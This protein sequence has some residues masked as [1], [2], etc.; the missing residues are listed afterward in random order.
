MKWARAFAATSIVVSIISV[1]RPFTV[2][3]FPAGHD[4]PAHLTYAHLFDR[5]IRQGQFPVRWTEWARGGQGQPLFNFYQPGLY[6]IV[7][8]VRAATGLSLSRALKVSVVLLWWIGGLLLFL[9]LSQFGRWPAALGAVL[10]V[11]SPYLM[12]DVNVRAAYPELAALCFAPGVLLSIDRLS[13]SGRMEYT[14]SGACFVALVLVCHLPAFLIFS[15]L[16][17]MYALY[18][19]RTLE[20]AGVR[21]SRIPARIFS[22]VLLAGLGLGMATFY[23]LPALSERQFVGLSV[24]TSGYFDYAHHFVAP[25]QWVRFDWGFGSSIDGP[26]D[27]LS[28]QIGILQWI[29]IAAAVVTTAERLIKG[30]LNRAAGWICF[31][32]GFIAFGMLMMSRA[33]HPVWAAFP[34]LIYLQFP[35]RYLMLIS[36]CCAACAAALLSRV[37]SEPAQI[38][39][40]L[41][42]LA[43]QLSAARP[44]HKPKAYFTADEMNIYDTPWTKATDISH[45]YFEVPYL[46]RS[47]SHLPAADIGRWTLIKGRADVREVSLK[48][49]EVI[50]DVNAIDGPDA[51]HVSVNSY[52]FPGWRARL[53]GTDVA[54][55]QST[56]TDYMTVRIPPGRHRLEVKFTNTPIRF[57]ANVTSVVS[58][59][60]CLA[61]LA[62]VVFSRSVR[63]RRLRRPSNTR[64]RP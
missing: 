14:F 32:L 50:L 60:V 53:D 63:D 49:D 42:A 15:P 52:P 51:T 28:F 30:R 57:I 45:V 18:L 64:G 13:R 47:A 1:A 33:S 9:L 16:F 56:D 22:L 19:R 2:P 54:T 11:F 17:V 12:L 20:P 48:D 4:T 6:Y 29:V 55:V 38:A 46:P 27:R 21:T 37:R 23:V 26:Q 61:G 34:P 3:G 43:G 40:V 5:A 59:G 10:F 8:G 58:L 62:T 24:M 7:T 41:L 31:W 25:G 35:W 36:V 39:I 44:Q